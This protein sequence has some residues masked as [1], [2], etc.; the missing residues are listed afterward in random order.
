M[1]LG[2]RADD[3]LEDLRE[4][5]SRIVGK[6]D[7]GVKA[8]ATVGAGSALYAVGT[9]ADALTGASEI[10]KEINTLK[11]L[12]MGFTDVLSFFADKWYLVVLLGSYFLYRWFRDIQ[13]ARLED[14]QTGA[15]LTR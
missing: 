5:G 2:E 13:Q 9:A 14:H 10:L 1:P 12:T 6:A 4:S 3:T 8:V 7:Q 15:T 11:T